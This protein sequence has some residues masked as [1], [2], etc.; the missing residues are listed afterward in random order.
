MNTW[1]SVKIDAPAPTF[2]DV[3]V[4]VEQ[5]PDW[6]ASM[7]RIVALDEPGIELGR[8][9]QIEQPRLPNLVWV[10]T[11]V[12]PG[13]SWTWR[14][15][16]LGAATLAWHEVVPLEADRTLARQRIEQRGPL[17]VAV[18]VLARRLTKRYLDLEAQGLKARS[19]QQLRRDASP[20]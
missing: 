18:G 17:G 14:Q 1:S 16:S 9:F 2:W 19:E 10:V 3:L 5:W 6:T 12:D 11:E 20:A 4:D 15:R 13:V 7:Q 8:R